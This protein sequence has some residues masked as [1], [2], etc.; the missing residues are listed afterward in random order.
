MEKPFFPPR[1]S[2][3]VDLHGATRPHYQLYQIHHEDASLKELGA[4]AVVGIAPERLI[5]LDL[6]RVHALKTTE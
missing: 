6:G 2:V 5:P 1:N 4:S 3:V